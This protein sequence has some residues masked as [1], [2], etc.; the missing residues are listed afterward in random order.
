MLFFLFIVD[1]YF[2]GAKEY[3]SEKDYIKTISDTAGFT[4]AR[5]LRRYGSWCC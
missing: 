4:A 5:L 2:K 3:L 1:M